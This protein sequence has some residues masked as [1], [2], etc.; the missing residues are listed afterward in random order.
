MANHKPTLTAGRFPR[1]VTVVKRA[2]EPPEPSTTAPVVQPYVREQAG[3]KVVELPA[4]MEPN[5]PYPIG[6]MHET[7]WGNSQFFAISRRWFYKDTVTGE[8]LTMEWPEVYYAE[9]RRGEIPDITDKRWSEGKTAKW[10]GFLMPKP[11]A[12]PN[13]Y[14]RVWGAGDNTGNPPRMVNPK[15]GNP[16]KEIGRLKGVYK[17]TIPC[18]ARCYYAKGA[19]CECSCGGQ[20]HGAGLSITA[21]ATGGGGG[22][23]LTE[24]GGPGSGHHGHE[25]RPGKRGGSQPSDMADIEN[26]EYMGWTLARMRAEAPDAAEIDYID[27]LRAGAKMQEIAKR[28]GLKPDHYDVWREMRDTHEDLLT[29]ATEAAH[30]IQKS[31]D[32]KIFNDYNASLEAPL[33]ITE[34]E[35]EYER[36]RSKLVEAY[37]KG[38]L[39]RQQGQY[40][41][42]VPPY[43]TMRFGSSV[44]TG[45]YSGDSGIVGRP[46]KTYSVHVNTVD[47]YIAVTG[48]TKKWPNTPDGRREALLYAKSRLAAQF[49]KGNVFTDDPIIERGGP[50]SGHFGHEGIPEHQGGSLPGAGGTA[51]EKP[52]ASAKGEAQGGE[53][54]KGAP[55]K[56]GMFPAGVEPAKG[57]DETARAEKLEMLRYT[58]WG[59]LPKVL[60]DEVMRLAEKYEFEIPR[61]QSQAVAQFSVLHGALVKN[62]VSKGASEQDAA[63]RATEILKKNMPELTAFATEAA[64]SWKE[65]EANIQ[66]SHAKAKE[67]GY[68]NYYTN[69]YTGE[70]IPISNPEDEIFTGRDKARF[71]LQLLATMNANNISDPND[72]TLGQM[73][74]AFR[75]DEL[76]DRINSLFP[77]NQAGKKVGE[78]YAETEGEEPAAEEPKKKTPKKTKE[79]KPR[80][81]IA[82][83]VERGGPGSGHHGHE[84]R[85]GKQGGSLP[86]GVAKIE[87]DVTGYHDMQTD[88]TIRA[89]DAE[90]RT[91]GYIDFSEYDDIISINMVEVREDARR[92]GI[93]TA[94]M[95]RLRGEFE[96]EPFYFGYSTE[97]GTEL[98]RSLEEKGWKFSDTPYHVT[99]EP[100]DLPD[101]FH[102]G[103]V[104]P[105]RVSFSGW[106]DDLKGGLL[107]TGLLKTDPGDEPLG[108]TMRISPSKKPEGWRVALVSGGSERMKK[109][110]REVYPT[111]DEAKAAGESLLR[112]EGRE[113]PVPSRMPLSKTN[114]GKVLQ[115]STSRYNEQTK[116]QAVD[117]AYRILNEGKERRIFSTG[118]YTP[119]TTMTGS[120]YLI[121]GPE[122]YIAVGSGGTPQLGEEGVEG[123]KEFGR[124][125]FTKTK[126]V[127]KSFVAR[128]TRRLKND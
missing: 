65:A 128:F 89:F 16:L 47:N 8:R 45:R 75:G 41:V 14:V 120:D 49:K 72:L 92:R 97:D 37:G 9:A 21:H 7:G 76:E 42:S 81:G 2:E 18:D 3:Q 38:E 64:K 24:R 56:T 54:P 1:V 84:G 26:V 17:D 118:A 95:E 12:G 44:G 74:E 69:A 29:K 61:D 88:G 73:R 55:A 90:G 91:I 86:S 35:A 121:H 27:Y 93:A 83:A 5:K 102:S 122:G 108:R 105:G 124:N 106:S 31:A 39:E 20:N 79:T 101:D 107:G 67:L 46:K 123:F 58:A 50:G 87:V 70:P 43:P 111:L 32:D 33:S 34:S 115:W 117:D 28:L 6:E 113:M 4:I 71:N 114:L 19:N 62:L 77:A 119:S 25:G 78:Y 110:W 96:G 23:A 85:P 13:K 94:L 127:T 36:A 52:A 30:R 11:D 22:R 59:D 116:A 82:E 51:A 98:R 103:P 57:D 53:A 40:F 63:S 15:T 109:E 80:Q 99:R 10:Q 48:S 66:T 100:W 60:Q 125:Y 68:E 112:W 126:P 104:D